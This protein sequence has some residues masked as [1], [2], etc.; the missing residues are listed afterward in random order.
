MISVTLSCL[1]WTHSSQQHSGLCIKH[2]VL[3]VLTNDHTHQLQGLRFAKLAVQPLEAPT[4][5][6]KQETRIRLPDMYA[7]IKAVAMQ[8]H[9]FVASIIGHGPFAVALLGCSGTCLYAMKGIA[10]TL[11]KGSHRLR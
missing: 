10:L 5:C 2:E 9:K 4:L 6:T 7:G 11:Q 1:L 3:A 8:L